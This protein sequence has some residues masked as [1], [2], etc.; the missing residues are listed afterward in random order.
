MTNMIEMDVEDMGDEPSLRG[1]VEIEARMLSGEPFTYG[2]LVSRRSKLGEGGVCGDDDRLIDRT[3]QK[4]RR[5]GLISFQRAGNVT[6]WSLTL[7]S[8]RK[9]GSSLSPSNPSHNPGE[10]G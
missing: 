5:R 7:P 10:E 8:N 4:L 2:G 3:I 1:P 9:D 6:T